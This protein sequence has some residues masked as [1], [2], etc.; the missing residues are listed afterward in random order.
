M[1]TPQPTYE[2]ILRLFQETDRKFQETDRKFQETDRKFQETDR[3]FQ[4]TDRRFQETDLQLKETDRKLHAAIQ[5]NRRINQQVS[6]QIGELG[7]AW[8]R[9][10]EDLVAPA[11]ERIF[12]ERGIPV[13]QV[14]QRVK[15]R[16]QGDTLEIDVLVVNQGHVL[17]VEVKS[18][19]SVPD[20][21]DFIADLERFTT[22]FP[23]YADMQLYGAVA[24]IGIESGADRYA[25]RQGLFVMAQSGDS[26]TLLN[27]SAFIPTAW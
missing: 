25:Y 18:S 7:G 8:G 2:D 19:L 15:R 17:A 16:R 10:V 21:K 23:E 12:L 3:K 6:K 14:S 9:F 4:E 1:A 24:G 5:E 27:D 11:C 22:F 26:V 20:V 13:D